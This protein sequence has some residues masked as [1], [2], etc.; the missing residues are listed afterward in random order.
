MNKA[1]SHGRWRKQG[2]RGVSPIIATILLVAITVVLAAVL[3]ILI[4]GLTKG[5][6]STPLSTALALGSPSENQKG[7]NWWY[8]F[9]IQAAGGGVVA[10]NL[11][12]QVQTATGGI[13]APGG[14]TINVLSLSGT[15]VA[16]YTLSSGTWT[17]GGTT[18]LSSSQTISLNFGSSISGDTL[19]VSGTGSF[20]GVIPVSIP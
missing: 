9:S 19:Q 7:A 14:A 6:G 16:A 20:Q 1:S 11:N 3:Y 5:P 10:N 17:A 18:P 15:S 12:F 4:S 13:V 2:K 8:N